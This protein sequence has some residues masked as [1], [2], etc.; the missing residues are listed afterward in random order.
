MDLAK[1]NIKDIIINLLGFIPF[2]FVLSATLSKLG[3]MFRKYG[4]FLAVG[5]CF[6][7]SLVI[8][9]TQAWIP[10]RNSDLLDLVFNTSG[11]WIGAVIY[12]TISG[13]I[14]A[15]YEP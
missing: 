9:V 12:A 14:G 13:R 7:V 6:A 11:G 10:S 3:G 8:E 5:V 2:G 4:I 1:L 15:S